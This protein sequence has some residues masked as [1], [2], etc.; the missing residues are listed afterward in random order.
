MNI[1]DLMKGEVEDQ[2][3]T[4]QENET[5]EDSSPTTNKNESNPSQEGEKEKVEDLGEPADEPKEETDSNIPDESNVP[6]NKHP[7]FKELIAE[8]KRLQEE[9]SK[10]KELEE[11]QAKFE[12]MLKEE[13]PEVPEWF[14]A[15]FG[16]DVNLAK[17]FAKYTEHQREQ[18]KQEILGEWKKQQ[19]EAESKQAEYN[20]II[21]EALDELRESGAQFEKNAFLKVVEEYLPTNPDGSINMDKA[22]DIYKLVHTKKTTTP[23]KKEVA[24]KLESEVETPKTFKKITGKDWESL[25]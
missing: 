14:K 17:Q 12:K 22:Y 24:K 9:N 7:R 11:K 18:I 10:L 15:G 1:E 8:K 6:F 2:E 5:L 25:I 16:D 19:T 13:N 23:I 3:L 21:D 4:Q 20:K